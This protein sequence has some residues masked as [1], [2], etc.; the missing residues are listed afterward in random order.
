MERFGLE[1][2]QTKLYASWLLFNFSPTSPYVLLWRAALSPFIT[3]SVARVRTAQTH[4]Q[5]LVFHEIHMVLLLKP[6]K[7]PL[8]GIPYL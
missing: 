7:V 3:Q 5:D 4:M 6:T 2:M 1:G 8:D